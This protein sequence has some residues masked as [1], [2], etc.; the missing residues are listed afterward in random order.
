MIDVHDY[1]KDLVLTKNKD[2]ACFYSIVNSDENIINNYICYFS[3]DLKYSDNS[4]SFD[5]AEVYKISLSDLSGFSNSYE[6][7]SNSTISSSNILYSNVVGTADIIK[8]VNLIRNDLSNIQI[9]PLYL[10]CILFA[11]VMPVLVSFIHHFFK[12]GGN[13]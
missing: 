11:L 10:S 7:H 9:S 2:Y 5:S 8:D 12:I 6:K 1:L 4:I 3:D 13:D